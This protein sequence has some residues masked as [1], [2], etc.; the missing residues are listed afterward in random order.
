M[1]DSIKIILKDFSG[2]FKNC[3]FVEP[4]KLIKDIDEKKY[5][6]DNYRLYNHSLSAKHYLKVKHNKKTGIVTLVGSLRK[7]TY[8]RVTLNDMSQADFVRT[9]KGITKELC[10]SFEELKQATF[11]HCEIGANVRTRIPAIDI[12]PLVVKYA[13]Y[14]RIDDYI[15]K[16]TLYFDGA[17]RLLK[18]YVK[19]DEIAAHSFSE[20]KRVLKKKS[21]DRLKTKGIHHLRIELTMKNHRAFKNKGLDYIR[22]IKDLIDHYSDLYYLWTEEISKMLV[23]NRLKFNESELTNKEK[24]IVLGLEELGFF[25]FVDSYQDF[26]I[27]RTTTANSKKSAKSDAFK[28]VR[29]VLDKYF[30]RKEYNKFTFRVD[31]VKYLIGKSKPFN[32]KLPVLIRNLWGISTLNK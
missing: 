24:D 20:E 22:T 21:F 14:K 30:D 19:D 18:L 27:S 12:L 2:N 32:L 3:T 15:D 6:Y 17:D 7:R 13:H 26:C 4:K 31:V 23:Y 29:V 10:I 5:D 1:I 28:D 25:E 9:L 16:G 8:N 11:T